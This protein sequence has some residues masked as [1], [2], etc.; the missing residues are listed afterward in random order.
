MTKKIIAIISLLLLPLAFAGCSKNIK[1]YNCIEHFEYSKN[2]NQEEFSKLDY[3]NDFSPYTLKLNK[4]EKSFIIERT[5]INKNKETYTGT[6]EETETSYIFS[7][8]DELHQTIEQ[9][10]E[11]E[12]YV[13]VG[14][15]LHLTQIR[16]I[17]TQNKILGN[18][19]VKF[20]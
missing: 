18:K 13:K 20:K 3:T 9:L 4:K 11:K 15:E 6:F 1:T 2:V 17:E 5:H 10:S 7:Y 16:N 14:K 8:D 12:R 19:I